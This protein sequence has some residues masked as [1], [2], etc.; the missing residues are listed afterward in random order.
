VLRSVF[1]GALL[2]SGLFHPLRERVYFRNHP[3]IGVRR[4]RQLEFYAR[5]LGDTKLIFDVGAN[6]GQRTAV[7]LALGKKVVAFE[8]DPRALRQLRARFRFARNVVIEG[9]ALGSRGDA[10]P[11]YCCETDALSSLSA[12]HVRVMHDVHFPQDEWRPTE[13]VRVLTLDAMI[14][15]Y[16]VPG[17]IKIDVEG[18]ELEV[19]RGLSTPV[20]LSFEWHGCHASDISLRA[21]RVHELSKDYKFNYC[22][23]EDVEFVAPEPLGYEAFVQH[24]L[25]EL[26]RDKNA[27]GDVYALLSSES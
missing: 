7:F 26:A 12:E 20:S 24:I 11:L 22:C 1:R 3:Q 5:L 27:W 16:G 14:E 18:F 15:K 4:R 9:I 8:P 10:L 13:T 19:L 21:A 23:G 2:S 6:V 25:P 17:F